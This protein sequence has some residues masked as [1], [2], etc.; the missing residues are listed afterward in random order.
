MVKQTVKSKMCPIYDPTPYQVIQKKG[1]M[2]TA[3][4]YNH[5]ITRNVSWF[6]KVPDSYNYQNWRKYN[7]RNS[8]DDDDDIIIQNNQEQN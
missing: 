2:V 7:G 5:R 3:E 4:R 1:N 8:E 6:K